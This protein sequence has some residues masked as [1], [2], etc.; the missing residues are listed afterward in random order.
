[1]Q[2]PSL[3]EHESA[4][5]DPDCC[6]PSDDQQKSGQPCKTGQE[7]AAFAAC[8]PAAATTTVV[9]IATDVVY[10]ALPV[11]VVSPDREKTLRPP[12]LL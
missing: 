9:L 11:P 7:C 5:L 12:S 8:L 10:P 1:M 4:A 6:N 3:Q 2:S